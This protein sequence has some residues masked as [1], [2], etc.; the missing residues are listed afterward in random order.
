MN[1]TNICFGLFHI[2]QHDACV[3]FNRLFL[4]TCKH[5]G[6]VA[7]SI[8]PFCQMAPDFVFL[9][10]PMHDRKKTWFVVVCLILKN[11][12]GSRITAPT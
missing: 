4:L 9:G 11:T 8:K 3:F 7:G 2:V 12:S 6:V 5:G 10:T 1:S